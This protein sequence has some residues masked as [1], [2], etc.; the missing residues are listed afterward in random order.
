MSNEE[1]AKY[2]YSR[3]RETLDEAVLLA[4]KNHWNAVANRLYYACFYLV[5]AVLIKDDLSF[6]SHRGVKTEFHRSYIK[7]EKLTM[8]SGK[9]YGRLFNLRQEGD[10]ADFKRYEAEDIEPFIT[11]V[12]EFFIELET[13]LT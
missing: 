3:A 9:L 11:D 8:K 13:L 7:T 6:D 12:K 4:E 2:R 1:L 10:Y 5:N